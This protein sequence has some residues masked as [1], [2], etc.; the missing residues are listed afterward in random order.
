M[1]SCAVEIIFDE[2][3]GETLLTSPSKATYE[4]QNKFSTWWLPKFSEKAT[5]V[6]DLDSFNIVIKYQIVLTCHVSDCSNVGGK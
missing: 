4:E 1:W 3:H 2:D 6:K 5:E